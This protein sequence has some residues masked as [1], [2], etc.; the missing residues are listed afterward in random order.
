MK[1]VGLAVFPGFQILDLAAAGVF[2]IANLQK[3]R[4]ACEVEVMSER[5]GP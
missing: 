1:R 5:S 4:R 3:P 2:E